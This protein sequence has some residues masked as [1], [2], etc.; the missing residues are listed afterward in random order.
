MPQ[1]RSRTSG[2]RQ[3]TGSRG[4]WAVGRG[5]TAVGLMTSGE[6]VSNGGM[7]MPTKSRLFTTTGEVCMPRK[8]LVPI[9]PGEVLLEEFLK[10]LGL[11]QYRLATDVS[12]SPR[13]INEI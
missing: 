13:R 8:K 9:H 11:S 7:A 6:S 1:S 10:P 3:A 5:N 2:W 12:V 4:S